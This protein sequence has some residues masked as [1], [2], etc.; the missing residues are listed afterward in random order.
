M[1]LYCTMQKVLITFEHFDLEKAM[2]DATCFDSV[3]ICDGNSLNNASRVLTYCGS[4]EPPEFLASS[5]VALV[6]FYTDSTNAFSGF[7]ATYSSKELR[8]PITS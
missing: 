7:T 2:Q 1:H 4:T 5:N 6:L 8:S 3:T